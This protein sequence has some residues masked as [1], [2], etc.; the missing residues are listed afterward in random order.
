MQFFTLLFLSFGL[1]VLIGIIGAIAIESIS[2]KIRT[3]K[4]REKIEKDRRKQEIEKMKDDIK[5]VEFDLTHLQIQVTE[6]EERRKK[7]GYDFKRK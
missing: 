2:R 5:Q 7:D 4:I 3:R 1:G 6:I